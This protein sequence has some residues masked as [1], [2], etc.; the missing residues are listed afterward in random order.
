MSAEHEGSCTCWRDGRE[1]TTSSET[2]CPE[3]GS[4]D[5]SGL[6]GL[7]DERLLDLLADV[8]YEVRRRDPGPPN[9][10][11]VEEYSVLAEACAN[12]EDDPA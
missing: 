4:K 3:H 10:A 12:P 2:E 1:L 6:R 7:S 5:W 11:E 9:E 8:R